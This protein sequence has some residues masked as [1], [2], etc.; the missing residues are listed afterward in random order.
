MPLSR[1]KRRDENGKVKKVDIQDL[2][3]KEEAYGHRLTK[4]GIARIVLAYALT[5]LAYAYLLYMRWWIALIAFAIGFAFTYRSVLPKEIAVRY[6]RRGLEQRNRCINVIT[7]SMTNPENTLTYSLQIAADRLDGEFKQDI[8]KLLASLLTGSTN[9]EVHGAFKLLTDKY[10]DDVIFTQFFEQ[11]E[12]T[13]FDGKINV[14][15]FRNL[16]NYHNQMFDK[17]QEYINKRNERKTEVFALTAIVFGVCATLA[18]SNG[19]SNY[20]HV[21]AHTFVGLVCSTAFM[22]LYFFILSRF[23]QYYYDESITTL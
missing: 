4:A 5:V 21:Y 23:F 6:Y 20:I 17:Q 10:R 11:L 15:T 19:L 2:Q 14:E 3:A 16:K 7:Q 13:K 1:K 18:F 9:D 12:T 8:E 22:L